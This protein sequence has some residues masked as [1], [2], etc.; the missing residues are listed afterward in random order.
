M[1]FMIVLGV[2]IAVTGVLIEE[3]EKWSFIFSPTQMYTIR[4][5][6]GEWSGKFALVLAA[7]MMTGFLMWLLPKI[8]SQNAKKK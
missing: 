1:W 7:M 3:P 8:L 4:S 6:H 2:P 5:I